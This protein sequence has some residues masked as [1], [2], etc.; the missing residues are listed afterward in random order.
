MID[1]A[2]VRELGV[3]DTARFL[4]QYGVGY[5]DYTEERKALFG[6]LNLDE[7]IERSGRCNSKKNPSSNAT[8]K[9]TTWLPYPDCPGV[10]HKPERSM[11]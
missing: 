2:L 5:G 9:D 3:A 11:S 7:V 10:I 6:D 1:D 8:E 4:H